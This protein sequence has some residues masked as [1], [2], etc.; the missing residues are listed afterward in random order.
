MRTSSI[1]SLVKKMN[2]RWEKHK[3]K[4]LDSHVDVNA[5]LSLE[6]RLRR[7]R[8]DKFRAMRGLPLR[9]CQ[10]CGIGDT[11]DARLNAALHW[12]ERVPW[13][14]YSWETKEVFGCKSHPAQFGHLFLDGT[15]KPD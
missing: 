7:Y 15:F 12:I 8:N 11:D 3:Q 5:F 4:L 6:A 14:G 9:R 10:I 13:D 1:E 2:K